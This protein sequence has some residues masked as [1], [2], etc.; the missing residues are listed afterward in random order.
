MG[1]VVHSSSAGGSLVWGDKA[2]AG[3]AGNVASHHL[4][5]AV[6]SEPNRI[7]AIE[8]AESSNC[9]KT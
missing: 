9:L 3:G 4:R 1:V 5:V 8:Y 6:I 2:H 7:L